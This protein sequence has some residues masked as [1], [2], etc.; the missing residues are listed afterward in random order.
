MSSVSGFR[1]DP[2]RFRRLLAIVSSAL[3]AA[4]SLT[5][6]GGSARADDSQPTAD[7]CLE[8]PRDQ[9]YDAY[10]PFEVVD[11]ETPH[12]AQVFEVA[13]YPPDLGA[14]STVV[15]RVYELFGSTCNYGN[16]VSWLGADK[17]SLPIKGFTVP[18]LPT[19]EQWEA[20]ARWVACSASIPD[21]KG[22]LMSLEGD[23]PDLF[24]ATPVEDWLLCVNSTPK[25]GQWNRLVS[26]T[27]KAKWLVISGVQ[28]KGKIGKDYPRDMQAKADALCAKKG[29]PFLKNGAKSKA[30]AGLGPKSDFPD[31]NP[32]ADCFIVKADWN[33]KA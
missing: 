18:R 28:V 6:V 27:A 29:K 13:K 33:G 30:V 25:S 11:C 23:L 7:S 1:G 14:P 2:V 32:F 17:L 26:C 22:T 12:N 5:V 24:A 8:I 16:Y 31:G 20:G 21:A 4:A 10:G 3:V 19:D 9:G 15:D